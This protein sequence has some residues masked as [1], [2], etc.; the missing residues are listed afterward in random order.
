MADGEI[1]L[2]L[3]ETLERRLR[4]M[5]ADEGVTLEE[6][7]LQLIEN[8]IAGFGELDTEG[9]T[10]PYIAEDL[11]RLE[12]FERTRMGVPLED[13]ERWVRSLSTDNPLSPPLARKV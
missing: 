7:G 10:G 6:L 13:V 9:W 1:T 12:E 4:E 2:K 3:N 8:Q 5:A 11:A